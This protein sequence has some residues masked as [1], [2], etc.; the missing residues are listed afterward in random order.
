MD[1]DE[2]PISTELTFIIRA[3]V[4]PPRPAGP[5]PDGA[6]VLIPITGGRFEGPAIAG[7]VL[8]GADR[9]VVRSDGVRF[10]DALYEL[11][12]D[13][14][15]IINVHNSGPANPDGVTRTSP[16][17]IAP[18]GPHDWLNKSIF[19]GTLDAHVED[20]YVLIRVD[21]II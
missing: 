17:F 20:G 7:S 21:R 18:V 5:T 10:V 12:T 16:R 8:P 6:R 14:G 3:E 2:Q 19:V 13:D 1:F 9:L 11:E 15:A 4:E